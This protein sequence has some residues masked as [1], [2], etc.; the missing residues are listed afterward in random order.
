M[1]GVIKDQ[2]NLGEAHGGT[3][4]GPAKDDILHL[5]A[6]QSLGTLFAHDPENGVGDVGLARAVRSDNGRDILFKFQA[7]LV[8]EGLEALNF[9]SL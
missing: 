9:Q 7:R 1:S 8:R 6:A 4:L 2:G 3:D 5:A